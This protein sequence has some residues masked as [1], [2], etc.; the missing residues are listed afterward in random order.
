MNS[1]QISAIALSGMHAAET[2]LEQAA[3][4][5]AHISQPEDQVDLSAEMVAL[6]EARNDFAANANVMKTGNEVER[7]LLDLVSDTRWS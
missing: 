5:I 6:L 4:R 1:M 7:A 2:K 3:N